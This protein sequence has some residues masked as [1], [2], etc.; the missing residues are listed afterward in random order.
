MKSAGNILWELRND[1]SF[2]DRRMIL[3]KWQLD[4]KDRYVKE[5]KKQMPLK[6]LVRTKKMTE[7]YAAGLTKAIEIV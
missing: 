7:A 3:E 2:A 4:R 6:S 1:I 5:I